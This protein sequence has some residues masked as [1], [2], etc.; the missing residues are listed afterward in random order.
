M[1]VGL[2]QDGTP[3]FSYPTSASSVDVEAYSFPV[4]TRSG[5]KPTDKQSPPVP[6]VTS[7]VV[8][9]PRNVQVPASTVPQERG[10]N[11]ESGWNDAR[12]D[13]ARVP[14]ALTSQDRAKPFRSSNLRFS[15][16][17][18]DSISFA[19]VEEHVLNTKV[20]LTLRECIGMSANLQ[21]RFGGLVKTKREF[22]KPD[23]MSPSGVARKLKSYPV[24]V[25]ECPEDDLRL[26]N[27]A[28]TLVAELSY[29]QGREIL[30]DVLERYAASVSLGSTRQFAMVSGTVECVW[31][32]Q[33]V[34][35]LVDTG[36]ELNLIGKNVF[37]ASG[38]GIDED[39]SRWSLR[40]I[41]GSP[42][43]LL[44]CVRDAPLQLSGK[45]FDHH[46]FV[47]SVACGIHDGILGQPWLSFFAAQFDYARDGTALLRAYTSGNRDGASVTLEICKANHPRNADRLVLTTSVEEVKDEADF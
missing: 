23:D 13:K 20:T 31:G 22:E 16:A 34:V 1:R 40:G 4:T 42:I 21:K 8:L 14:A 26:A 17:I 6:D 12:R 19:D 38:L 37:E 25:E 9:P 3:V 46:F 29:E 35:L 11:T 30:D 24:T 10:P 47:S 41:G 27:I 39:G 18:Q 33:K 43:P 7:K 32:G 36:S 28:P 44:G 5:A 2:C 15:S 45:N